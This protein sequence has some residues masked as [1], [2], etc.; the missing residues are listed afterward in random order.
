MLGNLSLLIRQA[1][2]KNRQG[3]G[4]FKCLKNMQSL[5]KKKTLSTH[6]KYLKNCDFFLLQKSVL[7]KYVKHTEAVFS[8]T[9]G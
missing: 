9:R 3:E 5:K 8:L 6:L 4:V 1:I 7:G 2:V